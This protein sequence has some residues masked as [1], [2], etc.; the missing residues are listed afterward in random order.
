MINRII[1]YSFSPYITYSK[2]ALVANDIKIILIYK[3]N[4]MLIPMR[5]Y[6]KCN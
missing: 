5:T 3:F 2:L 4:P 6:L 1:G